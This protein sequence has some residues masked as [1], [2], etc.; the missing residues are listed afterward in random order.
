MAVRARFT[1]QIPVVCTPAQRA[2]L[3]TDADSQGVSL[4]SV[5]RAALDRTYGLEDGEFPAGDPRHD[6]DGDGGQG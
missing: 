5:V 4:A 6:A 2:V 3:E 1:E